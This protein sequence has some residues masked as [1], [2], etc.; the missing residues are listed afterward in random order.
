[1]MAVADHCRTVWL[2]IVEIPSRPTLI[3]LGTSPIFKASMTSMGLFK[4]LLSSWVKYVLLCMK[5][6]VR[7]RI[8]NDFACVAGCQQFSRGQKMAVFW[9][10]EVIGCPKNA[11]VQKQTD[12]SPCLFTGQQL[13]KQFPS[14]CCQW[15]LRLRRY[16]Y[17]TSL[18]YIPIFEMSVFQSL[19]SSWSLV[20]DNLS[21]HLTYTRCK[22]LKSKNT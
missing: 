19:N 17:M 1:M 4:T 20:W 11:S 18:S 10:G 13:S 12:F 16:N 7:S 2:P 6:C 3:T 21:K 15:I 22:T 8:T 5:V 9:W 14:A